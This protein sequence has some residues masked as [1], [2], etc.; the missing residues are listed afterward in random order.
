MSGIDF[1]KANTEGPSQDKHK[2]KVYGY[3][4]ESVMH[5]TQINLKLFLFYRKGRIGLEK[6]AWIHFID[7]AYK[8]S[9]PN[10]N[11]AAEPKYMNINLNIFF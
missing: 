2:F 6:T 4:L 10:L 3:S 1:F 7:L 11:W 9:K 5:A 8:S